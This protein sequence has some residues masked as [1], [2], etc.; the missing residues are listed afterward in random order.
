[1]VH[2]FVKQSGGHINI[3]TELDHG[4]TVRIYLPRSRENEDAKVEL[5]LA[6]S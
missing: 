5:A 2:G 1:M 6:R 3:Y 4:S